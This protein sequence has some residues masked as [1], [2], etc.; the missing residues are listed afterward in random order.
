[1]KSKY[2]PLLDTLLT[3]G[4]SDLYDEWKDYGKLGLTEAHIPELIKMATD[5]DLFDLVYGEDESF[6]PSH[7]R[8]ALGQL[9]A[10]EAV[11]PL[12]SLIFRIHDFEDELLGDDLLDIFPM[13]G[14]PAVE[15]L[16]KYLADPEN[17]KN[18]RVRAADCLS[19]IGL[20]NH[21]LKEECT[22]IIAD[23]LDKCIPN[24]KYLNGMLVLSLMDLGAADKI[25]VI[26]NAFV[27]EIVDESICGDIED[28]EIVFGLR[29]ERATERKSWS[30]SEDNFEDSDD[31]YE[32]DDLG[33][34]PIPS[35]SKPIIRPE[36]IGRNDPC[37]CGSGK[38][39]KKCC[40]K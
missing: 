18:S 32:L 14:K 2:S 11:E 26:R 15:P 12:V 27:N 23:Q 3:L 1:M 10:A 37:P 20:K 22:S 4:E 25:D 33:H 29:I 17:H 35:L 9:K 34:I 24:D 39:Y 6:A 40:L 5:N 16:K 38:K 30:R 28:A 19:S 36:K 21:G 7:A 13:I 31:G 8:R